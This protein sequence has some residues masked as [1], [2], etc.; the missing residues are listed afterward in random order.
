M[1]ARL[2]GGAAFAALLG[3][4]RAASGGGFEIPD[5]GTEGLGRGGAFTAKADDPT[6]IQYNIAGLAAQKGTNLLLDGHVV[7][8]DYEFQRAGVY[9]DNPTN[10][11]TPWGGQRYP[12]VRD[13]GG[14]FFAPFGALTSDLGLERWT[15]AVGAFGPSSVGN[16]TY[17]LGVDG[18]PSP[19][20]YDAA[21]IEGL[22]IFPTVAAAYRLAPW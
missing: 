10:P 19:A 12:L 1:K 13:Q 8:G 9:G 4:T 21:Q 7:L 2:F 16:R 18:L 5:N 11:A 20:R 3:A 17:P 14:P 15:F 6:A 22:I